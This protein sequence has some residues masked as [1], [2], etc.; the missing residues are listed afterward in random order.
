MK[1]P[2]STFVTIFSGQEHVWE[3]GAAMLLPGQEEIFN[4]NANGNL[5]E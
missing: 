3:P 5:I 4:D 1:N 2:P